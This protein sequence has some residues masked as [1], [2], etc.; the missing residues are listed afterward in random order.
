[1]WPVAF[2]ARAVRVR[3]E[4]RIAAR[5]RGNREGRMGG[6]IFGGGVKSNRVVEVRFS[7]L[8]FAKVGR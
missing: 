6:T 4:V 8:V 7:G 1:M 3:A 5:R 2:Q